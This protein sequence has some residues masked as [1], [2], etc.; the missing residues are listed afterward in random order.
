MTRPRVTHVDTDVGGDFDDANALAF[1]MASENVDLVAVTTVGAGGNARHRAQVAAH[2]LEA[3]GHGHV[4][5]S[6][7]FD[8]PLLPN[9]VLQQLTDEWV[10]NAY[11]GSMDSA[12]V[13]GTHAVEAILESAR[14]YGA[15]LTLLCI[16]C[17]TNVAVAIRRDPAT[18]ARTG[19]VVLMGGAFTEQLR[20]ANVAIDP[21]AADVVLRSGLP[22]RAVGVEIARRLSVPIGAHGQRRMGETLL[23]RRLERLAR[24]YAQAYRTDRITL[25]DVTA[26]AAVSDAELFDFAEVTVAVE[27]RGDVTRGMTVVEADPAFNAVAH[28][29]PIL[30]ATECRSE[31]IAELFAERVLDRDWA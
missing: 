7:G 19:A 8:E 9:R 1:L 15:D 2:L 29:T 11:D 31:R 13:T 17:L 20:E 10:L 3:G 27:L 21:E 12:Q 14:R 25:Y 22:V 4:P 28:G 30:V 6:A 24:R 18:M 26:A 5:V 16:G 23:G